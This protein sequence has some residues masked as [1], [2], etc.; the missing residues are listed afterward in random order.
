LN[1]GAA[2]VCEG[3]GKKRRRKEEKKT[4]PFSDIPNL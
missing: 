1:S 4:N 3:E 2:F